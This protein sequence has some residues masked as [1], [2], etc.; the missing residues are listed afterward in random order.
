MEFQSEVIHGFYSIFVFKCKV[1]CIESKLYLENIQQN[2]YMLINKAVVNTC[3]SIGIGNTQLTDFAAFI[4]VPSLSCSGYVQIQSNAAKAE[5]EVAWDEIKKAGEEERKLAIQYGDID[6]DGVPM[7]TVVA[8]G[9]WSKRSYKTKYDAL[10]GVATIIGYRTKKVMFI[11][12]RNKYCVIC[13]RSE[14]KNENSINQH[15]C[16]LNW[17]KAST[18]M[19]VDGIVEGFLKSV[20]MHGLKYNRLIGDGDSSVTKRLHEISPYGRHFHIKKIECRNHLMRNYCSKL[21][22]LS[23]ITKYSLR[24]RKYLL[25]NI[26]RFRSD[27]TKSVKHWR[28]TND[29]NKAQKIKGIQKDL[30]N[31]PFHR[32]GQHTNCDSYFCNG[33]N[34]QNTLNLVPKAEKNGIMSEIQNIM[35]RL[36][37]NAESLLENKNNNIC[38]Q[39]NSIINKHTGGKR[40]NFSGR[41]SYNTRVEAAVIDFNSKNFLRLIHK[42]HSNGFSPGTFGKKFINN[43]H[44]IRSNTIKRRQ[45]FPETRKVPK[46]KTSGP[47]A[48]YGMAEPLLETLSPEQMEIKKIDFLASLQRAN[49]EQIEI[50]TREQSECDK[51]F[52]ERRIRLTAS[53]F[54]HICKM[55]K[56]TSC[57][58]SVYDILYGSDIHSKAIQYGKDMEVV[59]RKKAERFLSKTIYAC[60]LFVDKEIGYLAASP[61]GMIED[62]TIV[63]IKCPFVARDN[64]SVVEAVHKK[65]LQHCFIDPS[66]QAVQLKK[67]SV[68]YYQIMG[69]LYI[70]KRTKCYFVVYTEKWL[71]VQEIFYDHSF[72]KSKMEEKLKTYYMKCLLPEIIDP[73]YPKR[74]LKS[75]IREPDYIC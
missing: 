13:Q 23:K 10:S 34:L 61:D 14:S 16:F 53:R 43:C 11:G 64:I 20:E 52:Q 7:I 8:D 69:Q 33:S 26:Q 9:Q 57:K 46:N 41:R 29:T 45:L 65:L 5:N 40:V 73:M 17:T 28:N 58:N 47:D 32:L 54:G 1:C 50:D 74:L 63:E 66:T 75:D 51:W 4:D 62:T 70:T 35:S 12:I 55:R 68:Y 24:V 49:V 21:T 71:H 6:I 31:A 59:A 39:F 72:W 44:R 37:T 36:I 3:Q 27:V 60:G 25:S 56:T 30:A 2:Q 42:K 22:A 67:E 38:E 15:E 18:S 48:D 19:E